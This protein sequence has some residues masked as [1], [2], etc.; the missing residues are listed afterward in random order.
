HS[1]VCRYSQ[2]LIRAD[3]PLNIHFAGNMIN[4]GKER[5][6]SAIH[7]RS[8]FFLRSSMS[9]C[10]AA[11][12]LNHLTADYKVL[13]VYAIYESY[14]SKVSIMRQ[15]HLSIWYLLVFLDSLML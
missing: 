5:S 15:F 2:F 4:S 7:P 12:Y 1:C 8:S 13:Y 10:F 14:G 6:K 11:I 3:I 9:T